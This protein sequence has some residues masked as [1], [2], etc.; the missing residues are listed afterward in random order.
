AAFSALVARHGPMVLAVCRGVLDDPFAVED[1]F[2]ATFLILVKKA[3]AIRRQDL[4]GP[5]LFGVARRV[6][7]RARAQAARRR[8]L[9][10]AGGG[11]RGGGGGARRRACGVGAKGSRAT[12]CGPCTRRST[13]CRRSTVRRWCSATSRA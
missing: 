5:W 1:A 7:L 11:G 6:A 8:H 4:L 13:G 3:G 12:T 10:G 2:Q 9:A